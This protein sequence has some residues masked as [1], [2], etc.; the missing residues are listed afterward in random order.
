MD[1]Q[2]TIQNGPGDYATAPETNHPHD[3]RVDSDRAADIADR[4]H[5]KVVE[6]LAEGETY[7]K[8]NAADVFHELIEKDSDKAVELLE[9]LFQASIGPRHHGS[10][11]TLLRDARQVIDD[12]LEGRGS[13]LVDR[14]AED[15]EQ[16]EREEAMEEGQPYYGEAA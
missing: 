15:L 1:Q 7:C 3:P 11:D 12:Y 16:K 2:A 8:V 13:W 10:E 4:A 14:M 5:E 9:R 6:R